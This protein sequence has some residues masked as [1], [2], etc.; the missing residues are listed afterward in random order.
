MLKI[1]SL[2]V[3]SLVL[4]NGCLAGKVD[5][6]R[7]NY[8]NG[9][10]FEIS[11]DYAL[12]G[13]AP[14]ISPIRAYDDERSATG[15]SVIHVFAKANSQYKDKTEFIGVYDFQLPSRW[16]MRQPGMAQNRIFWLELN[17]YPAVADLL[18]EKMMLAASKFL[19][20]EYYV[21]TYTSGQRSI[22]FCASESVV[23]A[24][25]DHASFL[26]GKFSEG[27]RLVSG[28]DVEPVQLNSGPAQETAKDT[29]PVVD[30]VASRGKYV[31][32]AYSKIGKVSFKGRSNTSEN[33]AL[34]NAVGDCKYSDCRSIWVSNVDGCVAF[35]KSVNGSWGKARGTDVN[36]AKVKALKLCNAYTQTDDCEVLATLC[37]E[38]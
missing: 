6:N 22:S 25:V 31:V 11:D 38:Y 19:C 8:A 21:Y 14:F 5:G 34:K 36:E 18:K 27:V 29:T 20:G 26:N 33:D 23:P 24:G 15:S 35:A 3:I 17:K 37:P 10:S 7:V 9:M 2:C 32:V 13:K 30:V 16:Y 12:V 4:L 1:F 28:T